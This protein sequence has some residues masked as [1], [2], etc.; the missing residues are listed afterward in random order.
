VAGDDDK[1]EEAAKS[2][3][4]EYGRLGHALSMRISPSRAISVENKR[5]GWKRK[6]MEKVLVSAC[7]LGKRVRY[8]S[9]AKTLSS[10]ILAQRGMEGV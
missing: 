10:E 5:F 1:P 8:D 4:Q 2:P 7:L 6:G 9:G 3:G